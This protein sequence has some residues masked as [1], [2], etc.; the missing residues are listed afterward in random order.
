MNENSFERALGVMENPHDG[1]KLNVFEFDGNAGVEDNSEPNEN[2]WNVF[3]E[4]SDHE[5]ELGSGIND[6]ERVC[7]NFR[8]RFLALK[9]K[10][11]LV[12]VVVQAD[13]IFF[14]FCD[15]R[16]FLK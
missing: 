5:T 12:S 3:K 16:C 4:I 9:W 11:F 14:D 8:K 7:S 13:P 1:C 15:F 10:P 6:F 2:R